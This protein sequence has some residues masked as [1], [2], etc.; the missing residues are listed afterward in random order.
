MIRW[1]QMLLPV[2]KNAQENDPNLIF[3]TATLQWVNFFYM[4]YIYMYK[5]K[6]VLVLT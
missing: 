3:T 1:I 6:P 5:R 2:V 4:P